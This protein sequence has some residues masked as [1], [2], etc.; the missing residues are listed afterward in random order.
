MG[1]K[2]TSASGLLDSF[3]KTKLDS[4]VPLDSLE[5]PIRFSLKHCTTHLG[6]KDFCL[7]EISKQEAERLY[8]RLGYFEDLTWKDIANLDHKKGFSVEKKDSEAYKKLATIF[9]HL[10]NFFHFRVN[11]V[12]TG[13]F[14]VFGGRKNDLCYIL[15]VDRNGKIHDDKHR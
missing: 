6:D 8:E 14:R 9:T 7:L 12:G 15:L 3:S 10:T 2:L 11:G 4:R 1:S 5:N 13:K